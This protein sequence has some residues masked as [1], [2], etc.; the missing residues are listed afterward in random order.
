MNGQEMIRAIARRVQASGGRALLVGGCVRDALLGRESADIDCEVHGVSPD[1]LRALL[2]AFGEIDESGRAYGIYTIKNAGI[3]VALPRTEMR[4]G[5]GH[6]DFAVAVDPQLSPA[7]AAARRDFTVNAI[8]RDALTGEYVDPLGGMEDLA[9]GVLRAVPGDGFEDDPLRVL[10]GAQFAARFRLTPDEETIRRMRRMPTDRLSAARV[11]AEMNKALLTAQEPDVFFRVLRDANA[12]EPW[13][14]E[15]AALLGV[16]QNPLHHPEGDAFEHTLLTLRAAAEEKDKSSHPL[17]FMLAA[18]THDLGKAVSAAQD[19]HGSWH[20]AGHAETGIPLCGA[21][22]AHL[23]A[24]RA[25]IRYAQD[26]CR[27]HMRVHTGYYTQADEAWMNLLFDESVCAKDLALLAVCDTRGTGK[28][29]ENAD[30]EEAFVMD[31]L[32]SYERI[33]SGPMPDARMLM[34]AGISP[35]PGMKAALDEARRRVLCGEAL[36]TACAQAACRERIQR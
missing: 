8:M 23:G 32:A 22:L 21:M 36:Q 16:Q 14:A 12:L 27:L 9:H 25:A 2:G 3:D 5:P 24:P 26:M 11:Y 13:F 4:T 17:H 34:A 6:K 15:L 31:R 20:A 33:V 19:E 28:P 1:A 29:R 18:L 35:G 10:R 30:R 7:Q